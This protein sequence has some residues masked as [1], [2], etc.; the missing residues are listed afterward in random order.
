MLELCVLQTDSHAVYPHFIGCTIL[1]C[2]MS[3]R[4]PMSSKQPL[5]LDD[6]G[7]RRAPDSD[8]ENNSGAVG[9]ATGGQ[10]ATGGATTQMNDDFLR[11]NLPPPGSQQSSVPYPQQP[12]Q[13]QP[14]QQKPQGQS[15][16]NTTAA[17]PQPVPGNFYNVFYRPRQY[18]ILTILR[19]G[20]G[21]EMAIRYMTT[22]GV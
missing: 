8:D 17:M 15:Q 7:P 11:V 13:Q 18:G 14:T 12:Q 6:E 21:V 20:E 4:F 16:L 2:K 5:L 1:R 22:R 19:A 9:G 10:R 3:F